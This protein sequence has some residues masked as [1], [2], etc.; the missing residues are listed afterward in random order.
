MKKLVCAIILFAGLI[1][2][3][4]QNSLQNKVDS[5]KFPRLCKFN[6]DYSPSNF[7]L[8]YLDDFGIDI[9]PDSAHLALINTLRIYDMV[10]SSSLGSKFQT[11]KDSLN[12]NLIL[13]HNY[14]TVGAF[15]YQIPYLFFPNKPKWFSYLLASSLFTDANA[16]DTVIS[17]QPGDGS[18]FLFTFIDT[19]DNRRWNWNDNIFI[20]DIA[21]PDSSEM[22]LIDTTVNN[23]LHFKTNAH[24][25]TFLN[26]DFSKIKYNHSAS[27]KVWIVHCPVWSDWWGY[28]I[29]SVCPKVK[30]GNDSLKFNEY[31]ARKIAE[32]YNNQQSLIDGI[33]LDTYNDY[34]IGPYCDFGNLV[35]PYVDMDLNGIRDFDEGHDISWINQK[36]TEG[37]TELAM[38]LRNIIGP[39]IPIV[40]NDGGINSI[41]YVNGVHYEKLPNLV[42]D[43]MM[44][45]NPSLIL[46]WETALQQYTSQMTCGTFSSCPSPRICQVQG[47]QSGLFPY[48]YK[49]MR[50][51]LTFTLMNDGFYYYSD[52]YTQGKTFW[53]FD[54]Y[55][56]D[57][58][59]S[60]ITL[61]NG[62][63][64]DRVDPTQ[65]DDVIF[66]KLKK[67]KGYLGFPL[68]KYQLLSGGV[69]RRDFDHGVV[70]C[71]L[72]PNNVEVSLSPT[73]TLK[74]IKGKQDTVVNNGEPI[75]GSFILPG[76]D[77]IILL[78]KYIFTG[79]ESENN[80]LTRFML[81]QNYPN[82]FN[83]S[84]TIRFSLPKREHVTLK[85][86]DVL[87]RTVARLVN[88]EMDAGEHSVVFDFSNLSSGVY[89]YRLQSEQ[90]VQRKKM[91]L[92]K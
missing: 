71:N 45:S 68:G 57:S 59:G 12:P 91:E 62:Y 3:D 37:R 18:K 70:F 6:S 86:F 40:L 13:F 47:W 63:P 1:Q 88:E 52:W 50:K 5:M 73:D 41:Q 25:P 69:L 38:N 21:N 10:I 58:T 33:W 79:I 81:Y 34:Y 75:I 31:L 83:P 66:Q 24:P 76:N 16:G 78:R 43:T 61:A 90:F 82:P 26:Y 8:E 67:A 27:S 87:G 14:N 74:R 29:S 56:V 48:D 64:V 84:T 39:N 46:Q 49:R 9:G 35:N 65:M 17:V 85:V 15:L 2:L 44:G 54:E 60:S 53:W 30:L 72:N 28:N 89:I 22:L 55:A 20:E 7:R 92:I 36:W 23:I 4:A 32:D 80:S 42:W 77:G 51:S 11:L 19:V